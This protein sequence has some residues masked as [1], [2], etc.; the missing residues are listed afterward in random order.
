MYESSVIDTQE[1]HSTVNEA[2][3]NDG[4]VVQLGTREFDIPIKNRGTNN[5][6]LKS[7]SKRRHSRKV[8]FLL[9]DLLELPFDQV[10][11][12]TH[13]REDYSKAS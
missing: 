9:L 13:E 8:S 3:A 6:V 11:R 5:V 2:R 7:W 12:Q 10:E 4:H 1:D